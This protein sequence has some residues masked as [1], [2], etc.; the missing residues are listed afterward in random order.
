[1][2][3]TTFGRDEADMITRAIGGDEAAQRTLYEVHYA[4]AYRLTYLLLQDACDAEEVV[5]DAFVYILKNL[6]R[7]DA[8]RGSFWAWLR[9]TLVSRCR[10][11]RRRRQLP[12]ISLEVL[13]AAE[14]SP[15]DSKLTSDPVGML[16]LRGT[17]Q[18]IWKALQEVSSGA[19]DALILR[20]Y[21]GLPYAEI[22]ALLGCSPDA[23]RARV[24]HGK[25]QLRHIFAR[26]LADTEEGMPDGGMARTVRAG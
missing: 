19:R 5:Q 23:A 20:Y 2:A 12:S 16:E 6:R 21:E 1:M 14:R 4:P 15:V 24:A 22:A 26:T 25:V 7:Y 17:Q 13:D 10:N 18:A 9:V 3:Q 11:K 8:E